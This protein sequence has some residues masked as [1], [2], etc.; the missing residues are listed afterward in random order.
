MLTTQESIINHCKEHGLRLYDLVLEDERRNTGAS[1][2]EV[3][4]RL[5]RFLKVMEESTHATLESPKK[6][7][8]GMIDGFAQRLLRYGKEE[9]SYSGTFLTEAMAMALSTL[10]TSAAM[11]IIVASPTAGSAG[12]LPAALM[13]AKG[14]FHPTEEELVKAM[15]TAVGIGQIIGYYANFSG[16][17]GGCQAECG[18]AAAMAAAALV[19]LKGGSV[20]A[21]LHAASFAIIDVLGLVCDPIAGLVEYPCTFRNAS[22]VMNAFISADMA[23]AGITSVVPFEEVA[24]VMG[25]VGRA[26]PAALRET[27]IGGLAGTPTGRRLKREVWQE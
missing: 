13:A 27:A 9:E 11:G 4:E 6:T 22:G 8:T 14:R 21:M 19:E 12:I 18:S 7:A 23:L 25:D 10:E 24:Q 1:D 17:E 2:D 20:E 15:L 16:A 5:A 26:L 3:K